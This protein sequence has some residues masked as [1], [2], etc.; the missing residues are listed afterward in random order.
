MVL[1]SS[2]ETSIA[3]EGVNTKALQS[4]IISLKSLDGRLF[5][6]YV[7]H[8]PC[9]LMRGPASPFAPSD[10]YAILRGMSS[11][12][13]YLDVK[14][15][16]HNDIKPGNL[17]YSPRRG[18]VLIDFGHAT[19]ANEPQSKG[20]TPW[21]IPPEFAHGTESNARDIWALGVTMLY[22]PRK[23]P[24]PDRLGKGWMIRDVINHTSS[25]GRKMEAWLTEVA[26]AWK[27]L[28]HADLV[29]TT[30]YRMLDAH[31]EGRAQAAHIV[32][33]FTEAE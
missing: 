14:A 18:A 25:A 3:V 29:E 27:D 15:V 12:L 16:A 13:A 20:E 28:R 9:S 19:D 23:L 32:A 2:A 5:A 22:V 6:L 21:Y 30:V 1:P 8:L 33:V 26:D 31:V 17:V 24:L 10:A 4:N 7:E 11:A